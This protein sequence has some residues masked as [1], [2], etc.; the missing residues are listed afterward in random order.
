MKLF[1][2]KFIAIAQPLMNISLQ[3][4]LE[5]NANTSWTT[6]IQII[7]LNINKISFISF[8]CLKVVIKLA[9]LL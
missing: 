3:I 5:I 6:V 9:T 1:S 2:R 8:T 7:R 4:V